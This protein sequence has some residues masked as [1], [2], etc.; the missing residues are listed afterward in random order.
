MG[1]MDARMDLQAKETQE[2]NAQLK[3]VQ[4]LLERLTFMFTKAQEKGLRVMS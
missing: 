2:M 4:Q 3:A 1:V